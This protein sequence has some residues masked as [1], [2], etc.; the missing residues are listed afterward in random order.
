[1]SSTIRLVKKGFGAGVPSLFAS[2]KLLMG[3]L[4]LNGAKLSIGSQSFLKLWGN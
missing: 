2:L 4:F 3:V 1:M